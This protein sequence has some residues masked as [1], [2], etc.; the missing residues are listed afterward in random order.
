MT[1]LTHM[2]RETRSIPELTARLIDQQADLAIQIGKSLRELNPQVVTTIA[3]GSS[4]HA[5]A[6]LKYAIELMCSIPVSSTGPSIGS[7]YDTDMHLENA[8][9]LAISQ[10]GKSPDIVAMAKKAKSGGSL[11]VS[12][13]NNSSSPLAE[14]SARNFDISAGPELSVAA[15]KTF[16]LS[17][18]SGLMILAEWR[19]D[20]RL[21]TAIQNLPQAFQYALEC[22]WTPLEQHIVRQSGNRSSFLILGRGPAFAIAKECAL[23]FKETC[24]IHAESYS[25][26]EVMHGPIAIIREQSPVLILSSPDAT[27]EGVTAVADQLRERQIEVFI[28]DKDNQSTS[29]PYCDVGHPL[30]DPLTRVV[31]FYAFIERLSRRLGLDPDQPPH[32]NKVTET[33]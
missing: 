24:Q 4:D 12:L 26:A 22:E 25:T 14:I 23:K 13:T 5:A 30:L 11:L 10:S 3:R 1:N 8:A 9:T 27:R 31:S 16:V 28:T 15:T 32:L 29:L 7:V 21:K 19:C 2:A 6:Y 20:D 33:V 17:I 18:I